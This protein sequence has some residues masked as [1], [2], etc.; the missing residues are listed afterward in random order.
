MFGFCSVRR[1]NSP[2]LEYTERHVED[3]R[4]NP[5]TPLAS[6]TVEAGFPSPAEDYIERSLDL[7]DHLIPH[8]AATFFVRV[9]GGSMTGAGI[10]DGDLLIVDRSLD[11]RDRSVVIAILAGELTVKRLR[12]RPGRRPLL[13]LDRADGSVSPV[14]PG[15]D[16][17][18]WGVCTH[19]IHPLAGR[20]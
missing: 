13:E 6:S 14:V 7:N 10:H 18:V 15:T 20:V 19:V 17:Q 8:P 3:R 9:R 1:Y 12:L 16:F 5:G 11:P 4:E 2:C